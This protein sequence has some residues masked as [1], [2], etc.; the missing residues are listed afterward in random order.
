MRGLIL[1]WFQ[2]LEIVREPNILIRQNAIIKSVA[3]Y[4]S[5]GFLPVAHGLVRRLFI[6][7]HPLSILLSVFLSRLFAGA[8]EECFVLARWIDN[9]F[10]CHAAHGRGHY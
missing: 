6:F 3:L 5:D 1:S 2:E 10:S 8:P 7:C 9:S 4:F